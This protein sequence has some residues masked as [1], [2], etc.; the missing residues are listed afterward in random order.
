MSNYK[1]KWIKKSESK[2]GKIWWHKLIAV[3]I[4]MLSLELTSQPVLA[5]SYAG[6][7]RYWSQGGS[8]YVGMRDV[9]CLI[10]AQAKM[11]YEANV[12]RS[13]SFNPDTW[14][15]WLLANGGIPSST[16][17]TMRDHNIPATYAAS[18]GKNLKYLGYWNA[19]DAQLWFNINA[20]YY[21]IVHVSGTNTG[22]SHFV[23]LDNALSKET[24]KLYCYDSFSDRGSVQP[25]LLSRYSIHNGGHVYVGNN[26][27]THS[28][29]SS[30]TKEPTCTATGVRTFRCSCGVSYTESIAAKGH[31]YKNQVVAPT[32]TEKGYTLHTCSVCGYSC[33]DNYVDCPEKG[34]DG[35]YYSKVLPGSI[36]SD[37]YEIEYNNYYEKIQ[38]SSPGTGWTK[39]ATIKDEWQNSGNPYTSESD[40]ATSDSRILVGSYYYHFC[41]PS[42]GA[43]GNYDQSGNFVHF[44]SIDASK[45]IPTYC[46]VDNG[47]P[48][49]VLDWIDGGGR[50]WCKSGVTCDG[51]YGSHGERCKAWYKT[52]TYQDRI[53]VVQYK[54]TKE[55][56]WIGTKDTS[57]TSVKVRFKEIDNGE[58]TD[59]EDDPEEGDNTEIE[60]DPEEEDDPDIEE[61]DEFTIT[62]NLAGG[63]LNVS[64]IKTTD[65]MLSSLPTPTK[66]DCV[67][68]GW[69]DEEGNEVTEDTEFTEDTTITAKWRAY[70]AGIKVT[71]AKD[72]YY[73]GDKFDPTDFKVTFTY[74]DGTTSSRLLKNVD[75]SKLDMSYPHVHRFG[76]RY[77]EN[78]KEFVS[79]VNVT[80]KQKPANTSGVKAPGSVSKISVTPSRKALNLSWKKVSG[81]KGYQIQVSAKKNFAGAKTYK[82][83][84]TKTSYKVKGLKAK[85]K[86]YV[87][88]RAYKTYKDSNGKTKN[89]YG[90]Y[91]VTSK[92]TK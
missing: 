74:A 90:K 45:V 16:N 43:A 65:A 19:D 56:G 79:Y 13:A 22:G 66:K 71:K 29:S 20:G 49:Y 81:A 48:Y 21:T 7:Y 51:S 60:D 42:A 4:L 91:K 8:D 36:T 10:T 61:N 14:Y 72:V 57:A 77:E 82:V 63:S 27:H 37:K 80:I 35:W 38:A 73:V 30:V 32:L 62:L 34:L 31:S 84:G 11:L 17:L 26:T 68:L 23:L 78:G 53:H 89:V 3:A 58:N 41:G 55:S 59:D 67:F 52:N 70:V 24:G 9:G 1:Q 5:A 40:L 12:N 88:I 76:F 18:L 83:K 69:Y 39:A 87:R 15:N 47:H 25:Q 28:Y 46:G 44:D 54:Y 86:Y 2:T 85:K 64:S 33:K 50:V 92:K 6:D 75:Y